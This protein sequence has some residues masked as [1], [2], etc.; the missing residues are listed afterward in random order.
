M[1]RRIVDEDGE[2]SKNRIKE[3]VNKKQNSKRR[4]QTIL[5]DDDDKETEE[6]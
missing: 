6:D 2:S 4:A 1:K 3:K 5:V